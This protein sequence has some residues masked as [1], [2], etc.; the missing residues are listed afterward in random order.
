M[1]GRPASVAIHANARFGQLLI[2]RKVHTKAGLRWKA[3][4]DCG[5][6]ITTKTQY[7]TRKPNPQ[8]HCGAKH[9]IHPNANPFPREKRIWHMMHVR[10]ENE[11]HVSYKDYGGRG[12]RVCDEW[13]KKNPQGWDNF[14]AFVG[15]APTDKH[16]I[17]RV[18]PNLG[19]QPFQ[20]DGVTRQV[21][22]ATPKQQAN[23]QRRHYQ[24]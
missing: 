5:V 10:T 2:L 6:E 23:N 3:R 19:Y 17:D 13:N 11:T 12:I 4:C 1:A 24:Q 8:T 22:W 7:L 9:H 16:S 14:I 18:D 21:R 15:P 20:A